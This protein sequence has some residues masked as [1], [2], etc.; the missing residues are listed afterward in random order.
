MEVRGVLEDIIEETATKEEC[1]S[2]VLDFTCSFK[3]KKKVKRSKKKQNPTNN[4]ITPLEEILNLDSNEENNPLV[5]AVTP[6]VEE[7]LLPGQVEIP[8]D[9]EISEDLI[10]E[11]KFMDL[12]RWHCM[13][14]PQY[15]KSCGITSLVSCWNYLFSSLGHGTLPVLSQEKALTVLGIDPPFHEIGFGSFTGNDT[16]T[17]WFNKLCLHFGLKGKGRIFWKLH[18]KGRTMDI[19]KDQALKNLVAGLKR[20]KQAFIYHCHNHYMCPIG[21]DLAPLRP[22]DAYK[23]LDDINP[24]ELQAYVIIGEP[25]KAYPVFHTKKWDDIALD[26]D[27]QN[28]NYFNIRKSHLGVQTRNSES[29]TSGKRLG[30]NLHCLIVFENLE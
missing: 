10:K 29:F 17:G 26:I 30:K 18:G 6:R 13:S 4:G 20:P 1:T 8:E 2:V 12:K 24:S 15:P 19:D 21:S 14:R 28:P 23:K 11:R 5:D 7:G 22:P 3:P 16:L 27:Q 25:S 9:L